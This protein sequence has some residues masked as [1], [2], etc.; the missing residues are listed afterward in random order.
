MGASGLECAFEI[1]L[2]ASP[3]LQLVDLVE[4]VWVEG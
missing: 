4:A 1:D 3:P 2:I